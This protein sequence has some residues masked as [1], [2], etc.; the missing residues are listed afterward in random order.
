MLKQN[1]SRIAKFVFILLVTPLFFV[2]YFNIS[3]VNAQTSTTINFQG[4]IVRNDTG[5][6][7]LN[8]TDG[9]PACVVSGADTC[10]F[11][12]KYYSASTAG[13]L[14]LTET[15]LNKEIGAYGGVFDLSLGGGTPTAGMYSNVNDMIQAQTSIYVEILF[16]PGG[17]GSYTE[18]FTRMPLEASPYAIKSK[19]SSEAAGA[20]KFENAGSSTGYTGSNGMVYYDTTEAKLKLYSGGSWV[21]LATGGSSVWGTNSIASYSHSPSQFLEVGG[22]T[23]LS[24]FGVDATENRAW[25]H[26]SSTKTGFSVYSNYGGATDWPLV[27][28][29]ADASNFGNSILQLIQDGTGSILEGYRGSNRVFDFDNDGNLH[30]ASNGIMYFEKFPSL[31]ASGDLSPGSGEGCIYTVGTGIYWDASCDASA[32]VLINATS[33]SLWTDA[34]TFSYLTSTTDDLVLGASTIADGTFV[35]DMDA[36]GGSYFEIDSGDN[37]SRLFTVLSNGNVGIG[38]ASPGAKL[39]I[40]GSNSTITNATGN[41]TISP[42]ATLLVSGGGGGYSALHVTKQS[43]ETSSDVFGINSEIMQEEAGGITVYGYRTMVSAEHSTGTLTGVQANSTIMNFYGGG[44]T[45]YAE[46]FTSNATVYSGTTVSYLS[47]M[48]IF[49]PTNSGTIS[50]LKGLYIGSMGAGS[51]SNYSIYS[52]G[53]TMY[54]AGNVGIGITFPQAKL[55]SGAGLAIG[56]Y[57]A[58]NP[59]NS[60]YGTQNTIQMATQNDINGGT[61]EDHTGALIWSTLESGGW[62]D[63]RLKVALGTNWGVYNTTTPAF[64]LGQS[65][66]SF[67]GSLGIGDTTPSYNLDVNGLIRV[68]T[69]I[70]AKET[71]SYGSVALTSGSTSLPGYIQWRLPAADGALGT[72]LGYMGWDATNVTLTL[73]NSAG[74]HVTGGHV[75]LGIAPVSGYSLAVSAHTRLGASLTGDVIL[76]V[77]ANSTYRYLQILNGGASASGVKLG[78]LLVSDNYGYASP[79][80][81]NVV[82]KGKMSIGADISSSFLYLYGDSNSSTTGQLTLMEAGNDYARLYFGNTNTSYTYI[83]AANPT[84]GSSINVFSSQLS[85]DIVKFFASGVSRF[86]GE[87]QFGLGAGAS[88]IRLIGG[89]YGV[90]IRND[91]ANTNF[92]ITNSGDQYGGWNGLR[93]MAFSLTTGYT[94][95]ASGHGDISERFVL[96]DT[97]TRGMILSMDSSGNQVVRSQEGTSPVG[98]VSTAPAV[99]M[100]F[101]GRFEVG[102]NSKDIYT[103][104]IVPI[105]LAGTVPTIVTTERGNIQSGDGVSISSIP[106]IGAKS[107]KAEATVGLALE[108]TSSWNDLICSNVSTIE[109]IVWPADDDGQNSAKPCYKLSNG[110]Y[111]GKILVVVGTSWND[112]SEPVSFNIGDPGWYR[113][114]ELKEN[115]DYGKIKISNKSIGS[116]Q[117]LVFN[118]YSLENSEEVSILSNFSTGEN[119]IEKIRINNLNGNKYLEIYFNETNNNILE[120]K[121]ENSKESEWVLREGTLVQNEYLD[122]KEY[123]LNG[124]LLG[125]SDNLSVTKEGLSTSGTIST[126]GLLSD[127]GNTTNRWND[128]Y[129]KGTIRLGSGDGEGGIRYNIETKR[130]EFSND[131]LTWVEMGDLNSNMVLSPEYSGAILYADGTDNY[132]RMTSDAIEESGTFQNYYQWVSDK[133]TLQDYDILVKITLPSDFG[134]WNEDAISLDFMTENSAS[135]TY[136]NVG[137]SL[138]GKTGVNAQVIGGISTLPANWE[139]ISIKSSEISECNNA[140][141]SCTLRISMSS[142]DSYFVRVG[143][144]TLN[145]NRSL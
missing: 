25:V 14:F 142:K 131:G 41:I 37:L 138:V 124:V 35:F 77:G 103:N 87:G 128:I 89:N 72:R 17:A 83:I 38:T 110:E 105:A 88:Q 76:D 127:I 20:F 49:S 58:S 98:I 45:A 11:Q 73:E 119:E 28:F 62:G 130:L 64:I 121:V 29:K 122:L 6:E 43:A 34:G 135:T 68:T 55:H 51:S 33:T 5:Y 22:I 57:G 44:T 56:P 74:F 71:G 46:G 30:L 54:H 85:N 40:G 129:T 50:N 23:T 120:I 107:I 65:Y 61:Y 9:S 79:G 93:P 80:Q 18:V 16:A 136:N 8:V 94:T 60:T 78:G 116:S 63:A 111:V 27:T 39:E 86:Y 95:F 12:V 15:Y 69:R 123:S 102:H 21:D 75:G 108:S 24:N 47:M 109:S 104:E 106:G 92:L 3:K 2:A 96:N 42:Q 118:I 59:I 137:I 145:Y 31:P 91:G 52:E 7:G 66:S 133:D 53:G 13:T 99:L 81:N 26:G 143:D 1:C 84:S 141:D 132:G 4:K 100:G 19:Y 36:S 82:V 70:E 113:I 140:G 112:P 117:N 125:I 10:D 32:P 115:I 126:T 48:R 90:M 144:I 114:G 134:G 67:A 139:R 101:G 97:A